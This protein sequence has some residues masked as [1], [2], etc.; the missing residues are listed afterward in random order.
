MGRR[1]LPDARACRPRRRR[2]RLG[3]RAERRALAGD[4]TASR[5]LARGGVGKAVTRV[6][7]RLL[8][9]KSV[10]LP[11][12]G[13]SPLSDR[14]PVLHRPG[15]T[16]QACWYAYLIAAFPG[17]RSRLRRRRS[18]RPFHEG[19]SPERV[20]RHVVAISWLSLASR[21]Q[22]AGVFALRRGGSHPTRPRLELRRQHQH[23]AVSSCIS[24]RGRSRRGAQRSRIHS[25][26]CAGGAVAPG[27]HRSAALPMGVLVEWA[28]RSAFGL[29]GDPS[30]SACRDRRRPRR[31]ALLP[32]SG[33][34]VDPRHPI[35]TWTE[36]H[37]T[38]CLRTA[39]TR[40]RPGRRGR[41]GADRV[42]RRPRPLASGGCAAW[43]TS[44]RWSSVPL[45]LTA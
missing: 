31:A 39:A 13:S 3:S 20:A 11:G 9:T 29:D 36:V 1:G 10:S 12:G 17:S 4:P 42:L 2:L 25:S 44:G 19:S 34:G 14:L 7:C 35:A 40:R 6:G 32:R 27:P 33:G 15:G 26:S 37:S 30:G 8:R 41:G 18:S 43:P 38:R 21:R 24:S 16:R 28:A 45:C 23:S 5:S 22:T